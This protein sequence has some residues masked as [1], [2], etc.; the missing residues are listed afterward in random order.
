MTQILSILFFLGLLTASFH[1]ITMML[2]GNW[3]RIMAA[4]EGRER[5]EGNSVRPRRVVT[6]VTFKPVRARRP[7]TLQRVAA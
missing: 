5:V 2:G 7:L 4:L 1:L 3:S 6:S